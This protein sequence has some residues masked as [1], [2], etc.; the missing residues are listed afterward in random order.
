M[1]KRLPFRRRIVPDMKRYAITVFLGAFLLFLVQP[2]LAR[3]ILPWYGGSP[4]VW[5]T[6][7]MFFQIFLLGGYLYAHLV[8]TRLSRRQQAVAHLLLLAVSLVFLPITPSETFRAAPGHPITGI[9]SLLALSVGL[10]YLVVSSSSPLLQRWYHLVT[11]NKSPYRLYALSNV[12]SLLGLLLYPFVVEPWL[13]VGTQTRVWS[14]AYG[15]YVVFCSWCALALLF[16]PP[17]VAR[18]TTTTETAGRRSVS[19]SEKILWLALA[20]CGSAA[21][22]ATTNQ[23]CQNVAV[24]PFLWVL[25]LA[26]Y[27]GSFII[28]F[29]H[30]R[31]YDRRFWL[32]LLM[33]S[34]I[35]IAFLLRITSDANIGLQIFAFSTTL[36]ACCMVC[37]GE[38][39]RSKPAPNQLTFFYLTIAAGGALGGVLVTIVAPLVF[40]GYWE[41]HIAL[42]ACYILAAVS[43]LSDLP[44]SSVRPW[45][46]RHAHVLAVA[47]TWVWILV[48]GGDIVSERADTLAMSRNFYGVLRVYEGFEGTERWRR[49][50]W[51]G[52]ISHGCQYLHPVF[53]KL[54]THYYSLDSGIAMAIEQHPR[55]ED[56][57]NI[58]VVGLGTGTIA[59]YGRY[60]DALRFYEI[61][62]D[63]L[64]INKE[65]FT[66]LE[67]TPAEVNV[68]LGDARISLEKELRDNGEDQFDVLVLDAFSSDAIPIHLLTKEAFVTY[69]RLL[70]PDGI[71]A[72][73]I[74]NQHF[75]LEPL[76]QGVARDL[77]M[78]AILIVNE[79][80]EDNEIFA[81]DWALLTEN[82][83]FIANETVSQAITPWLAEQKK[84]VWTDDYS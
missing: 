60:N 83:E 53:R 77:S 75:D 74:S 5:T 39:V 38:L 71:L 10:P 47:G 61:N 6:C 51:H 18:V 25:P 31:W 46:Q 19:L 20:A 3:Y 2:L 26:L 43:I 1:D 62:P 44:R 69:R 65:Y 58:G 15:G 17:A 34:Y 4:A 56:G 35:A 29:D 48:F 81:S 13:G 76:I 63:V 21:L 64:K 42:V 14:I 72:V 80:D 22:L 32:P 40:N 23:M 70:K 50:L 79:E 49:Y 7:M 68:V 45:F 67:D 57:L 12:G 37:H 16:R 36:F 84:V 55:R 11:P 73:H 78:I 28:C 52:D 9:L 33:V 24:V 27:L 30:D 41:Y 82:A 8:G 59:A 54:R 66:F